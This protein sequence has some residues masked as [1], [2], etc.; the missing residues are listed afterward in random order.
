[1]DDLIDTMVMPIENGNRVGDLHFG[2]PSLPAFP[3]HTWTGTMWWP[4]RTDE[5]IM[6]AEIADLRADN[7]RLRAALHG[8]CMFSNLDEDGK[9]M[10]DIARAALEAPQERIDTAQPAAPGGEA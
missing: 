2:I 5:D 7:K 4:M 1:M 10:Q 9:T 6:R 8:I 3:T